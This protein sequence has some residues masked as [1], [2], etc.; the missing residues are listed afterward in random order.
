MSS[1]LGKHTFKH[2]HAHKIGSSATN[3]C[4]L[5]AFNS[6]LFVVQLGVDDIGDSYLVKTRHT[7]VAVRIRSC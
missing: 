3:K 2:G 4:L 7:I 5:K 6:I 1:R